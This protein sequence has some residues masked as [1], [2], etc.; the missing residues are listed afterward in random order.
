MIIVQL[1]G[2]LGNQLFQY[3]AGLSLALHHQVP[4][5][6]DT[7][8]LGEPD[9]QIGT[10]RNFDLAYLQEP[11]E[12]ATRVEL[13][14]YLEES[15]LKKL[16]QKLLP[17]HKREIYKEARFTFDHHFYAAGRQIYLKGYR[18]SEQY[19]KPNEKEIRSR[20]GFRAGLMVHLEDF[21]RQLQQ[22]ESV[23]L[24]IR[25]G[26]YSA[27]TVQNYYAE[28]GLEYYQ[29]GIAHIRTKVTQPTY[30]VFTDDPS[31]VMQNLPLAPGVTVVS[32]ATSKSHLEDFWLMSQ[33]R[34]NIIANSSFS[35]WAAWLNNY[36]R[37]IVVAPANWF[38]KAKLDTRDLIPKHWVRL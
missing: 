21:A 17:P 27:T 1:K 3:A 8:L 14:P 35:W 31:W 2:G 5:K 33:C 4:V 22:E 37:K 13:Q 10:I 11:P 12:I 29:K 9:E 18:Q 16:L 23:A 30:Y 19:F 34:H 26:D 25:R 20:F 24:H 15:L 38:D 28:L 32:G 36:S 7:S 6:V